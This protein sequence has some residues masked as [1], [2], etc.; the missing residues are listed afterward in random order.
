MSQLFAAFLFEAKRVFMSTSI[1]HQYEQALRLLEEHE[2]MA[3]PAEVHGVLC[4]LLCGGVSGDKNAW[5]SEINDLLND[6][7]ALPAPVRHWLETLYGATWHALSEQNQLELLLPEEDEPLD[8]RLECL[9]DWVQS[10]LAGFA[11]MQQDLAKASE[12]LREMIT[13][14]S[15]ITQLDA[16][17]EED[18]ENEASFIVLYEHAKLGVMMAFEEFGQPLRPKTPHTLH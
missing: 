1:F 7:F 3:S 13:D 8:E 14:L 10:F 2:V 18:D 15:N 11:V 17:F 5:Q 6:G 9:A 16:D 12:E 4:G